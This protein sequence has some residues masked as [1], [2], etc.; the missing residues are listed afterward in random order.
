[1]RSNVSFAPKVSQELQQG[2]HELFLAVSPAFGPTSRVV[3]VERANRSAAPELLNDGGQI[4]RRLLELANP[5]ENVGAMLLRH[6]MWEQRQEAGDGATTAAVLFNAIFAEGLRYIAAGVDPG[7]LRFR[8]EQGCQELLNELDRM[9]RLRAGKDFLTDM[10]RSS[11]ADTELATALGEIFDVVGEH[12]QLD[13]RKSYAREIRY[14]FVEGSYWRSTIESSSMIT[15]RAHGHT[16]LPRPAV[17]ST[18]LT[19]TDPTELATVIAQARSQRRR[20]LLITGR[21]F[22]KDVRALLLANHDP[23]NFPIVATRMPGTNDEER[24]QALDDITSVAGGRAFHQILGDTLESLSAADIGGA[25]RAWATS[26]AFGLIGGNGN[27]VSK[28]AHLRM[29]QS[30]LRRSTDRSFRDQTAARIGRIVGGGANMWIGAASDAEGA[31]RR[32]MAERAAQTVRGAFEGGVVPGGGAALYWCQDALCNHMAL[33]NDEEERAA[34]RILLRAVEAPIRTIICNAG[35]DAPQ[36][37]ARID[38]AGPGYGY[39]VLSDDVVCMVNAGVFDSTTV[40]KSATRAAI[41]AASA[42]LTIAVVVHRQKAEV[43]TTP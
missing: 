13:I 19:L 23:W 6:L 24:R 11:G 17:V 26:E 33:A 5:N 2:I 37:L 25:Q 34:Y 43:S 42:A 14:E 29:L 18:D 36:T 10:A 32:Q 41:A 21:S 20:S 31:H 16:W 22:S 28:R 8:L 9:T 1:M 38:N 35:K 4:A 27:P 30:L 7:R 15:D 12:G 39:N 3:A 40:L